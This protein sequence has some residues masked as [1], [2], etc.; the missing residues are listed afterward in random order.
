MRQG[1]PPSGLRVGKLVGIKSAEC[2]GC[3]ECVAVCPAQGALQ[4]AFPRPPLIEHY[5]QPLAVW[6]MAAGVALLF[7]GIVGFCQGDGTLDL[8]GAKRDL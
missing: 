4:M 3:L 5:P 1:L 6:K 8:R 7:L 2:T